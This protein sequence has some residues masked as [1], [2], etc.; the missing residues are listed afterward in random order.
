M[1]PE[2][3]FGVLASM[4]QPVTPVFRLYHDDI[5]QVLYYSMED[6]PGTWIE[7]DAVTYA[8]ARHDIRVIA[9]KIVELPK[10]TNVRK[11]RPSDHGICCDPRDICLITTADKPHTRW[12]IK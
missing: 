1:T 7:I 5:G 11:L 10:T 2:E 3:F 8:Q 6:L 9:G 4:P 12:S